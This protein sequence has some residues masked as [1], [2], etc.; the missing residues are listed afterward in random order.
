MGCYRPM[1]LLVVLCLVVVRRGGGAGGLMLWLSVGA[2]GPAG[3]APPA[4]PRVYWA[5]LVCS[6][7][8]ALG[9]ART[10]AR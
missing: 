2:S 7:A 9:P 3:A 8:N 10:L 6:L 1:L 4:L 5:V